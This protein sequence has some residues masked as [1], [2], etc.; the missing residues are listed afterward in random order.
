MLDFYVEDDTVCSSRDG[1]IHT[2]PA[3]KL[4]LLYNVNPAKCIKRTAQL[5]VGSAYYVLRGRDDGSYHQLPP[6]SVLVQFENIRGE[7]RPDFRSVRFLVEGD[8]A[9]PDACPNHTYWPGK[10]VADHFGIDSKHCVFDRRDCKLGQYYIHIRMDGN[11]TMQPKQL[12]SIR[13]D[14]ILRYDTALIWR[15]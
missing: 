13:A 7:L 10:R 9:S 5:K 1:Q 8:H 2:V 14:G 15:E 12:Q 4:I 3:D 11:E 6:P